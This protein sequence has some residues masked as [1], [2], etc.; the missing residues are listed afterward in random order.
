MCVKNTGR[1]ARIRAKLT[2]S[3]VKFLRQSENRNLPR[4]LCGRQAH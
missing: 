3:V 1:E 2:S 4:P